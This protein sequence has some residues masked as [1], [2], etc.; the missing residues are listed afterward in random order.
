MKSVAVLLALLGVVV[1][2]LPAQRKSTLEI[3]GLTGALIETGAQHDLFSDAPL[4]GVELAKELKPTVHAVASFGWAPSEVTYSFSNTHVSILQYTLG[5]E[6]G[7]SRIVYGEHFF[8]PF[9]SFGAGAPDIR[10]RRP[11]RVRQHVRGRIRRP[12][13]RAAGRQHGA[14]ARG[15]R[16]HL[17]LSVADRRTGF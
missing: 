13:R 1:T 3:R 4:V 15:A 6:V 14:A 10:I 11:E 16:Q 7:L 9:V 5:I 8:K 17:L 12:G 2:A